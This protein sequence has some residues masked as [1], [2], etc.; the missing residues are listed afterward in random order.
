[1]SSIIKNSN[2]N[3]YRKYEITENMTP[4]DKKKLEVIH[5]TYKAQ[6]QNINYNFNQYLIEKFCN[7]NSIS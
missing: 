3:N 7:F 2:T 6:R 4:D 1:M 5:N